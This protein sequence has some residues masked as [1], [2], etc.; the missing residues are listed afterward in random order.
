MFLSLIYFV[1]HSDKC[2]RKVKYLACNILK[3]HKEGMITLASDHFSR[4]TDNAFAEK[5]PSLT[6]AMDG[7]LKDYRK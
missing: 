7:K 5:K 4:V 6:C 1:F 2:G 3:L